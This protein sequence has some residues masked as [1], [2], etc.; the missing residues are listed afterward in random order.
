LLW[1]VCSR[2][3]RNTALTL[4]HAQTILDQRAVV[5]ASELCDR[6]AKSSPPPR[7]LS[8]AAALSLAAAEPR[9]ALADFHGAYAPDSGIVV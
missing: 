2:K 3:Q 4:A 9:P 8:R 1:F 5:C 6:L 7:Y